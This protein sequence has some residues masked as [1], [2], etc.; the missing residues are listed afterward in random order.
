MRIIRMRMQT[1]LGWYK[2]ETD[3]DKDDDINVIPSAKSSRELRS[4][5]DDLSSL[6]LGMLRKAQ[7]TLLKLAALTDSES[8]SLSDTSEDAYSSEGRRTPTIN[9]QQRTGKDLAKR[10]CEHPPTEIT[11]K[12][13]VSSRRTMTDSQTPQPTFSPSTDTPSS[14]LPTKTNCQPPAPT[15]NARANSPALLRVKWGD[16]SW[17]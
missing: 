15:S 3:T 12:R 7:H 5:E 4:L 6:P 14:Q 13:P 8:E 1:R 10:S 9:H 16:W 2:E 11:S 17:L